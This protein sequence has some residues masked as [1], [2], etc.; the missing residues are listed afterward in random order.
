M[1]LAAG[2]ARWG[3]LTRHLQM[4]RMSLYNHDPD[5]C[6][7]TLWRVSAYSTAPLPSMEKQADKDPSPSDFAASVL[8]ICSLA[9]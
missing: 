8:P 3:T 2:T 5:D 7:S 1:K 6:G 4:H 9:W